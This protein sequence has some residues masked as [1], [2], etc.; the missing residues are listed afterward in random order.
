[1]NYTGRTEHLAK[2]DF[3]TTFCYVWSGSEWQIIQLLKEP[4]AV[5]Y[6]IDDGQD[7][8]A[9]SFISDSLLEKLDNGAFITLVYNN[10]GIATY[11]NN[12]PNNHDVYF[13]KSGECRIQAN[14]WA[15]HS[16]QLA[17]LIELTKEMAIETLTFT[18]DIEVTVR[19]TSSASKTF[20]KKPY[21]A[22]SILERILNTPT[23]DFNK[24]NRLA[25]TIRVMQWEWLETEL[26]GVDDAF[27]ENTLYD[28]LIK[29]GGY[30]NRFPV[31]YFNPNYNL[32]NEMFLLYYEKREI[33]RNSPIALQ[34]LMSGA[35]DVVISDDSPIAK[36]IVANANNLITSNKVYYPSQN[37]YMPARN[38]KD[39]SL[40]VT[41]TDELKLVLNDNISAVEKIVQLIYAVVVTIDPNTLEIISKVPSPRYIDIECLKYEDWLV[42]YD[43]DDKAY[44]KENTNEIIF[45]VNIKNKGQGFVRSEPQGAN[46]TESTTYYFYQAIVWT[47][48]TTQAIMGS[49]VY[50]NYFNQVDSLVDGATFGKQLDNY[51]KANS[52]VDY[53]ISKIVDNYV[54]ILKCGQ[55]VVDGSNEYLISKVSFNTFKSGDATKYKVAYVLNKDFVRRNSY[56]KAGNQIRKYQTY[57]ENIFDRLLNFKEIIFVGIKWGAVSSALGVNGFNYIQDASI[58]F[59]GML[60]VGTEPA[61]MPR[62]A[63]VAAFTEAFTNAALTISETD[64]KYFQLATSKSQMSNSVI[65]NMRTLDNSSLGFRVGPPNDSGTQVQVPLIYTSPFGDVTMLDVALSGEV[66]IDVQANNFPLLSS[67]NYTRLYSTAPVKVPQIAI[68]KDAREVINISLQFDY[69][70]Y[71]LTEFSDE[72]VQ[73]SGLLSEREFNVV[74]VGGG[75]VMEQLLKV[76][77]ATKGTKEVG[78]I[79]SSGGEWVVNIT[80]PNNY[81]M[82]LANS[83]TYNSANDYFITQKVPALTKGWIET[84]TAFDYT[85]EVFD[86][87]VCPTAEMMIA[88]LPI[89]DEV[90]TK[91]RVRGYVFLFDAYQLCSTKY[92]E[93]QVVSG[94]VQK[95]IAKIDPTGASGTTNEISICL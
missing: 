92:F 16:Y 79:L 59:G 86:D 35:I 34:T 95:I 81:R 47:T 17:E 4:T 25:K 67:S 21:N 19:Y 29:I 87:A 15:L 91:V 88:N 73:Y 46:I 57:Y 24:D 37:Q 63:I 26:V 7:S 80:Q 74:D 89:T 30:L 14:G 41:T 39:D 48:I 43:R 6:T 12:I 85:I 36:K 45:G 58:V 20:Y 66:E 3:L 76:N 32:E 40:T 28:A 56:I 75:P 54:D 78:D 27:N 8:A 83:I 60:S 90:G 72:F 94:D 70:E 62:V 84:G 10:N 9:I 61:P 65:V 51:Q 13:I 50:S 23:K 64:V 11:S 18:S 1:M 69:K 77:W 22:N 52:G 42:Q 71:G 2:L 55:L 33:N 31:I 44:F 38:A 53:T 49:G 93:M 68:D 5:N 82:T